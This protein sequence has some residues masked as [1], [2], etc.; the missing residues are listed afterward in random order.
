LPNDE[1]AINTAPSYSPLLSNGYVLDCNLQTPSNFQFA[2][3]IPRSSLDCS[4][5]KAWYHHHSWPAILI[6]SWSAAAPQAS[7]QV[8]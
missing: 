5:Q 4:S 7:L 3:H 6:C 2:D 8:R 1:L